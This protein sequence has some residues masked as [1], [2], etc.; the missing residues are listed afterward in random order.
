LAHDG[1]D[2]CI[3]DISANSKIAEAV[4]GEIEGMGRRSCVAIGD[5]SKY[6]EVEQVIQT[7]VKELGDLN[8]MYVQPLL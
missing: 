5:V 3:N 2:V 6:T 8:T 7:S 1:Y 4:A